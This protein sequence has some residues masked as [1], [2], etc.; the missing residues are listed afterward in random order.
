[1]N[2]PRQWTTEELER[3]V[4][5]DLPEPDRSALQAELRTDA[6]LQARHAAILR[7]DEALRLALLTPRLAGRRNVRLGLLIA[8]IAAAVLFAAIGWTLWSRG[9]GIGDPSGPARSGPASHHDPFTAQPAGGRPDF[10]VAELPIKRRAASQPRPEAA[11]R[12]AHLA[13]APEPAQPLRE[14]LSRG[15]AAGVIE[16]ID[17]TAPADRA[18]LY[19]QLGEVLRSAAT[20]DRVLDQLSPEGQLAVSQAWAHEPR[21]RTVAFQRL[22]RLALEPEL[23][24]RLAAAVHELERTPNLRPWLRSYR[25]EGLSAG[26]SPGAP[27]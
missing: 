20:A 27:G 7:G 10:V 3:L 22:Q 24:T 2:T 19:Q 18:A 14:R 17:G 26:L 21:L 11:P 23:Q 12:G 5:G 16:L 13:Q 25:L 15:D 9:G 6:L 4:D 8:P 1:M